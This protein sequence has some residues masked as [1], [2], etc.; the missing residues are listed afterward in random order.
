VTATATAQRRGA[1]DAENCRRGPP[2]GPVHR[3]TSRD[4]TT[5]RR[6]AEPQRTA[7]QRVQTATSRDSLGTAARDAAR[8]LPSGIA[9]EKFVRARAKRRCRTNRKPSAT[10]RLR[11]SALSRSIPARCATTHSCVPSSAFLRVLCA[12]ALSSCSSCP[13]NKKEGRQI[14]RPSR[15]KKPDRSNG[16]SSRPCD[17]PS[18]RLSSRPYVHPY[19]HPS[20]QPW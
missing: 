7:Q 14:C 3:A 4:R 10:L 6:G 16:A 19:G 9:N 12:S 13:A 15:S 11:A 18:L 1:E 8:G 17:R 2:L 5:Q 20:L